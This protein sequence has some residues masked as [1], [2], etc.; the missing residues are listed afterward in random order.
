MKRQIKGEVVMIKQGDNASLIRVNRRY[1]TVFGRL[2]AV[3]GNHLSTAWGEVCKIKRKYN[4]TNFS[5]HG[6]L[7]GM[8]RDYDI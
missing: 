6:Q 3:P 5:D 2:F 1:Y 8:Y 4:F 7:S